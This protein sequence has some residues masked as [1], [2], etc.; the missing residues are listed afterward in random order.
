MLWVGA[1]ALDSSS[2]AGHN[3]TA[4]NT[5]VKATMADRASNNGQSVTVLLWHM[6]QEN[7]TAQAQ[8]KG[9]W[10]RKAVQSHD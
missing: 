9:D 10:N 6:A 3:N 7:C 4:D 5:R 1:K 8:T 2:E